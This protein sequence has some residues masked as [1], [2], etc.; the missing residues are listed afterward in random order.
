MTSAVI[1]IQWSENFDSTTTYCKM[2]KWKMGNWNR[3]DST[4]AVGTKEHWIYMKASMKTVSLR[5]YVYIN[6]ISRCYSRGWWLRWSKKLKLQ[7]ITSKKQKESPK[8]N[9]S[10]GFQYSEL[11]SVNN[12]GK[13]CCPT[14]TQQKHTFKKNTQKSWYSFWQTRAIKSAKR[15]AALVRVQH[16]KNTPKRSSQRYQEWNN[17]SLFIRHPNYTWKCGITHWAF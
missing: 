4:Y 3:K 11:G 12:T 16:G 7:W 8:I 13:C 2:R 10:R 6:K 9:H 14:S 1:S 17:K 15:C 5:I